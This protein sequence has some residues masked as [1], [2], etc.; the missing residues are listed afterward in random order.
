MSPVWLLSYLSSKPI[1][2]YPALC[3]WSWGLRTALRCGF[4]AAPSQ[5]LLKGVFLEE[6]KALLLL[7]CF[8]WESCRHHPGITYS[9]WQWQ[10]LLVSP[11]GSSSQFFPCLQMAFLGPADPAA[12]P[13]WKAES[14]PQRPPF[15]LRIPAQ[16]GR[17]PLLRGL[18]FRNLRN[19]LSVLMIPTSFLCSF[20]LRDGG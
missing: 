12:A 8:L 17:W 16:A 20:S 9:P 3:C 15:E 11:A 7:V 2:P 14:Q 6:K 18:S 13:P 19:C 4:A 1:F 10:F 5:P